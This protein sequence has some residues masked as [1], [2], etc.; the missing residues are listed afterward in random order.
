MKY[1]RSPVVKV[2]IKGPT[3][4]PT[5]IEGFDEITRRPAARPH[6]AADRRTWVRQ[7]DVRAAVSGAWRAE[8][9][10]AGHLRRFRGDTRSASWPMPKA[11]AGTSR[12]CERKKLFFLDAQPIAR[13]DPV[14]KFR[15]RAGC[16]RRSGAKAKEMGARRIVF[17]ALDIVLAL[18]PDD[19]GEAAGD[20]PAARVAA[21]ERT[22]GPHHGQG[23]RRRG[24]VFQPAAV[25]LHAIHG[26]LRRDPEPP[27]GAGRVA[28]QS[29]RAEISRLRLRRERIARS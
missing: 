17:D 12:S 14:G 9:Q 21:G 5:G 20:L 10:G 8:L 18:L 29:A 13:P 27:R 22:D 26:G 25:R 1:I 11:S 4:A 15:P 2:P 23:R 3:K 24:E 7:D 16:W 19:G 6:H 28:A